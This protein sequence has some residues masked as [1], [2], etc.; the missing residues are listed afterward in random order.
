MFLKMHWLI[1]VTSDMDFFDL[2]S[3]EEFYY[4][5]EL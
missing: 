2:S 5:I 3:D 1:K 4:E